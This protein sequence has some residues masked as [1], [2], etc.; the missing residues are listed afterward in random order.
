MKNEKNE[1][2]VILCIKL[3]FEKTKKEKNMLGKIK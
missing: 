2:Y 1:T 3:T